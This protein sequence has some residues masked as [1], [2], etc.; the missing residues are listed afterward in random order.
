MRLQMFGTN[1]LQRAGWQG[2]TALLLMMSCR[3][4]KIRSAR[5]ADSPSYK[6][7]P[8]RRVLPWLC[9]ARLAGYFCF[10]VGPLRNPDMGHSQGVFWQGKGHSVL[11]LLSGA[12]VL[13]ERNFLIGT[14]RFGKIMR[15][16]V[17][18][19][20]RG[21]NRLRWAGRLEGH[22]LVAVLPITAFGRALALCPRT[23]PANGH[24]GRTHH[25]QRAGLAIPQRQNFVLL[26][27]CGLTAGKSPSRELRADEIPSCHDAIGKELSHSAV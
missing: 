19:Y 4:N 7:V 15:E 17:Y 25:A 6:P 16:P 8:S 23:H 1:L 21:L 26:T 24:P 13:E 11:P 10:F 14:Q 22:V 3:Q 12:I 27:V 20:S 2:Y 18:V 5:R 9:A